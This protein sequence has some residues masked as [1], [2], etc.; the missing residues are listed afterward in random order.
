MALTWRRGRVCGRVPARVAMTG[1][2]SRSEGS[3]CGTRT[4][5]LMHGQHD[6]VP[7]HRCAV[8]YCICQI[9][10]RSAR[11]TNR[12]PAPPRTWATGSTAR[13]AHGHAHVR[14]VPRSRSRSRPDTQSRI[15]DR[16]ALYG[17]TMVRDE[18]RRPDSRLPLRCHCLL[19][20][21]RT[22]HE[23]SIVPNVH[24]NAQGSSPPSAMHRPQG[25]AW[26]FA[27]PA[28]PALSH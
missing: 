1:P 3:S 8:L 9:H 16:T 27:P 19:C 7:C 28:H 24:L 25:C 20:M 6:T 18:A 21:L 22:H 13:R 15:S 2:R 17:C 14:A 4:D 11:S 12:E 10:V 26:A 23:P 5:M